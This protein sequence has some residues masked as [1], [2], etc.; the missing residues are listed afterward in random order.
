MINSNIISI[1][2][3]AHLFYK[4]IKVYYSLFSNFWLQVSHLI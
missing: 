1:E 3:A 2:N 4:K